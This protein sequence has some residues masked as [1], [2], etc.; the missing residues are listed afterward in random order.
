MIKPRPKTISRY[1]RP[2]QVLSEEEKAA[3]RVKEEK[4]AL[5]FHELVRVGKASYGCRCGCVYT[6][7]RRQTDADASHA[8]HLSDV[9]QH[10][11]ERAAGPEFLS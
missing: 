1:E 5:K 2:W 8:R 3:A 9:G 10:L 4:A 6:T 7:A 11:H